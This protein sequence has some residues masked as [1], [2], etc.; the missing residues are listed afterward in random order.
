MAPPHKM[1]SSPNM[2]KASPS[3]TTSMPVAVGGPSPLSN[4]ICLTV[5]FALIVKFSLCR[6]S[7][8]CPRAVDHLMPFGLF[9]GIGPTPVVPGAFASSHSGNPAERQASTHA[10]EPCC[11]CSFGNL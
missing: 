9:S 6:L 3:L 2:V 8:R 4:R 1:I 10:L 7:E 11:H 5:T